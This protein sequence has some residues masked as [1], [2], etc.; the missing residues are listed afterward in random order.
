MFISTSTLQAHL[1]RFRVFIAYWTMDIKQ[2]AGQQK[3]QTNIR[4]LIYIGYNHYTIKINWYILSISFRINFRISNLPG[5]FLVQI[6]ICRP[7]YNFWSQAPK[8]SQMVPKDSQMVPNDSEMVRNDSQS[9]P[10][11]SQMIRNDSQMVPNDSQMD[12]NHSQMVTNNPKWLLNV[13][14]W[15]GNGPK[16]LPKCPK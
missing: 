1:I 11:D 10:N 5:L 3:K 9:V 7:L 14:K 16:W 15:L 13:P 4:L 6:M 12:P 2:I 8:V